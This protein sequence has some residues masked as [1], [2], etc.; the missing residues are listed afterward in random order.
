MKEDYF[1]NREFSFCLPGDIY[2]RFNSYDNQQ[3]MRKAII[4]RL[5][6]KIDIGAVYNIKPKDSKKAKILT[7]TPEER[8]LVFDIDMSDYDDVRTCCSGTAICAKCWPFMIVAARIL[9]AYLREDFG[10]KNLL[11]VK[12]IF[13]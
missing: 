9:E 8:E 2:L 4:S 3:E 10:F 1:A 6:V 7:F 11:W 13:G 12:F 5:P